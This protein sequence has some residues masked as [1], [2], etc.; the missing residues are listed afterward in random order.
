MYACACLHIFKNSLRLFDAS[1]YG[2]QA[3]SKLDVSQS[4][5]T[6]PV[7]LYADAIESAPVISDTSRNTLYVKFT[8]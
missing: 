3:R 1:T 2:S 7:F 8:L 4:D 5:K 6:D